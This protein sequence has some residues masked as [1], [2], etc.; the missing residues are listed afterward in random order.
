MPIWSLTGIYWITTE[1]EERSAVGSSVH[2]EHSS[3][4]CGALKAFIWGWTTRKEND[5][6]VM[7][8]VLLPLNCTCPQGTSATAASSREG[9]R[10]SITAAAGSWRAN[11]W[12]PKSWVHRPF[13]PSGP[14]IDWTLF[15]LSSPTVRTVVLSSLID[16]PGMHCSANQWWLNV[17]SSIGG[18]ER[19]LLYIRRMALQELQ[20]DHLQQVSLHHM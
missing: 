17:L 20:Q 7:E 11:R 12:S 4:S 15:G 1:E 9:E 18:E 16:P 14:R 6:L 5:V 3:L 8:E 2:E 13:R 19:I 10:P